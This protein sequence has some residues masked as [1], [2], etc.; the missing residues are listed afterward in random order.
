MNS[1]MDTLST[2]NHSSAIS[3]DL[4]WSQ[5][6]E[7]IRMLNLAVAQITASMQEGDESVDTLGKSFTEMASAIRSIGEIAENMSVET[8][9][10]TK[11]E[12]TNKCASLS[13]KVQSAIVAF[14]FY[15]RITQRLSHVCNSLESLGDLVS[16][17]SRLYQPAE[18]SGLQTE[19]RSK[20]TME[21]DRIMFDALME[22]AA[23]ADVLKMNCASETTKE[24][25]DI[26][27]F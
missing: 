9:A 26:E 10:N 22:G 21:S 8:D 11:D 16:S 20:F 25:D 6:R 3:P 5:V 13:G 2:P 4:D 12:L 15:D 1:T 19:I 14:Q 27:L 23:I 7:T 17:D 18:W 24:N